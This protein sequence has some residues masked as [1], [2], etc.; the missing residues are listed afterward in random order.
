MEQILTEAMVVIPSVLC[1]AIFTSIAWIE[2][3]RRQNKEWCDLCN[4]IN[5]SWLE[6]YQRLETMLKEAKNDENVT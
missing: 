2:E 5:D 6:K 3:C 1:T 4:K